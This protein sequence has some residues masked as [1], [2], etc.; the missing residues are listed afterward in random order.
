MHTQV[1]HKTQ[2]QLTIEIQHNMATLSNHYASPSRVQAG[3]LYYA[4]F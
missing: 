1:M 3:S 4:E 2:N